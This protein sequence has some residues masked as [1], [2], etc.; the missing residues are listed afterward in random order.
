MGKGWA[1]QVK[2][3]IPEVIGKEIEKQCK[4]ILPTE[5]LHDSQGEDHE[6]TQIWHH[7]AAGLKMG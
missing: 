7:Q 5:G 2:K 3:L 6:K 1:K 4:G